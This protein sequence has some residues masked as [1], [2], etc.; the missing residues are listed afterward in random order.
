MVAVVGPSS[1]VCSV[2]ISHKLG[3]MDNSY[4]GTL[5][6]SW[7][8]W[9]CCRIQIPAGQI[10]WFQINI[11]SNIVWLEAKTQLLS[12]C[13]SVIMFLT[14]VNRMRRLAPVH[15]RPAFLPCD[16]LVLFVELLIF[17]FLGDVLEITCLLVFPSFFVTGEA[18]SHKW[19]PRNS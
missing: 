12:P 19:L 8:H 16:I 18:C 15:T 4:Y 1:V 13:M 17:C 14:I 10:L 7:H 11:C 6:T 5:H 2:V 3:K 9:F